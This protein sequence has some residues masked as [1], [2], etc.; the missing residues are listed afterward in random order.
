MVTP[1][2][3][4]VTL[5]KVS[6]C[7]LSCA[8][9][10]SGSAESRASPQTRIMGMPTVRQASARNELERTRHAVQTFLNAYARH[11]LGGT[12]AALSDTALNY[13]DCDYAEHQSVEM[14][15]KDLLRRWLRARFEEADRFQQIDVTIGGTPDG[16]TPDYRVAGVD[17]TRVNNPLQA[18]GDLTHRISFKLVRER[19]G[20]RLSTV[21][22]SGYECTQGQFPR[23]PTIVHTRVILQRFIDAYNGH[24]VQLALSTMSGSVAFRD[25]GH[26][27]SGWLN[28]K[29]AVAAWLRV[30]FADND[31][32]GDTIIRIGLGGNERN[33]KVAEVR[34]SRSS[35]SL[36]H[37]GTRS[38]ASIFMFRL[39]LPGDR[40]SVVDAVP[41]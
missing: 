4:S 14:R 16:G 3:R 36:K 11:D 31:H 32:L 21:A 5:S 34:A 41:G 33:P 10:L 9:A 29:A 22:L 17:V 27:V 19:R 38:T 23:V 25:R 39:T 7:V 40:I 6:A 8:L 24:D 37:Q 13:G 18:Q 26:P 1:F 15:K 2:G 20:P 30:P 35:T 12:L 28:G